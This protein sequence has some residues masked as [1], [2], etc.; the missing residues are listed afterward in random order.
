MMGV[1]IFYKST[2]NKSL[3]H[4]KQGFLRTSLIVYATNMSPT[5]KHITAL[6]I[7]TRGD[8]LIHVKSHQGTL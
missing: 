8:R 2:N 3:C 6:T 1:T 4:E 5:K 7:N